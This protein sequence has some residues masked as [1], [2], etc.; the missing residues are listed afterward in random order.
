MFCNRQA[1]QWSIGLVRSQII[2]QGIANSADTIFIL[3][4]EKFAL[5]VASHDSHGS[6]SSARIVI[7]SLFFRETRQ[8]RYFNVLIA[9]EPLMCRYLEDRRDSLAIPLPRHVFQLCLFC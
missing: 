3:L 6:R 4:Q 2:L 8:A 1:V 5:N 7:A 9:K